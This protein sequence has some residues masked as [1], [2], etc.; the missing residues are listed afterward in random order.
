MKLILATGNDD[1][2]K[3]MKELLFDL[4]VEILTRHDLKNFPK[5]KEDQNSLRGNAEKKAK[6]VWCKY[7]IPTVADDTG[8]FVEAL[9]GRPGV[10]SARYAGPNA[11]YRENSK[12]LLQEL[13]NFPPAKRDAAF[14][15][16]VVFVDKNGDSKAFLG[17]CKG[18]IAEKPSGKNGFG[19]D[20]IFHP[21]ESNKSFAQLLPE[22]KNQISHRGIALRKFYDFLLNNI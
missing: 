19:Y 21:L 15:T 14:R 11:S 8:L 12:K 6:N 13:K 20:P 10:K 22:E 5:T 17:E 4:P 18:F 2:I 3:E 7:N 9:E 16:A 1:K